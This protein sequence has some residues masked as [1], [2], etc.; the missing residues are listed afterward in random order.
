M[1]HEK[2]HVICENLCLEEGMT[3]EQI[4]EQTVFHF[5]NVAAMKSNNNLKDGMIVKTLGYYSVND[6]G[7]ANY[8]IRTKTSDDIENNGSIHFIDSDLVAELIVDNNNNIN[9]KQFGA[10][11]NGITNDALAIKNAVGSSYNVYFPDGEYVI[12]NDFV[13]ITKNYQQIR[14]GGMAKL[15]GKNISNEYFIGVSGQYNKLYN[16]SIEVDSNS[17]CDVLKVGITGNS[18]DGFT[19]YLENPI[20]RSFS[21]A[22]SCLNVNGLE[23]RVS[24]GKF[25]GAY[26]GI[27][28]NKPD[29]HC[30][31]AYCEGNNGHGLQG[32]NV[33]S[34]ELIHVHSYNNKRN[35]FYL[36]GINYSNLYGIYADTNGEVGIE[37]RGSK[38]VNLV[39]A[40]SYK[41][42]QINKSYDY[43]L[44]ET[45]N[46][47]FYG[48]NASTGN[49]NNSFRINT[50]PSNNF[51]N[52]YADLDIS[53][54][55]SSFNLFDRCNGVLA[56]RNNRRNDFTVNQTQIAPSST[57]SFT[58]TTDIRTDKVTSPASFAFKLK[59]HTRNQS[60]NTNGYG[61][62]IFNL[63][64]GNVAKQILNMYKNN[65]NVTFSNLNYTFD[66]TTNLG[67]L[68]FDVTNNSN[69]ALYLGG[70]IEYTGSSRG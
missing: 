61:E 63:G 13:N 24:Y 30:V 58:I 45:S 18:S 33:G 69:E 14:F 15:V 51:I 46:C 59:Y 25:K 9:V 52:C 22:K 26:N 67:S 55:S 40:W 64:N 53:I 60:S 42:G 38:H 65:E 35:G 43:N 7:G 54:S 21:G 57:T 10:K 62:I 39:G 16:L 17:N 1:A 47:N 28:V 41:S 20:L 37:I 68:T 12:E 32:N 48:C 8:L 36:S 29:F 4:K 44:Y 2:V 19:C 3:K 5:L 70:I 11:G 27:I 50:S 23:C 6:G 34:M 49:S 31:N 56:S 66:T